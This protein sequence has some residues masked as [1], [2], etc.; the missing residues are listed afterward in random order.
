MTT[1]L[2]FEWDPHKA[3]SNLRKHGVRFT[4]AARVF[5][6]PFVNTDTEG[7]N[8]GETRWKAVGEVEGRFLR[9]TYTT[10]EEEGLETIRIISARKATRSE[11]RTYERDS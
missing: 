9:V 8:H 10:R 7:T 2:R 1:N 6:D 5:A 3:A 4:T 11:R